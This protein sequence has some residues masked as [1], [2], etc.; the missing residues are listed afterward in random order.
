MQNNAENPAIYLVAVNSLPFYTNPVPTMENLVGYLTRGTR[1]TQIGPGSDG[2][3]RIRTAGNRI[4]YVQQALLRQISGP[5]DIL[6]SPQEII[7]YPPILEETEAE[8]SG[9]DGTAVTAAEIEAFAPAPDPQAEGE[10]E[11]SPMDPPQEQIEA[12]VAQASPQNI[13]PEGNLQAKN[14]EPGESISENKDDLAEQAEDQALQLP[15]EEEGD[16]SSSGDITFDPGEDPAEKAEDEARPS[17]PAEAT[18]AL[19]AHQEEGILEADVNA[20]LPEEGTASPEIAVQDSAGEA[21]E[22]TA[23]KEDETASLEDQS[24]PVYQNILPTNQYKVVVRKL[25]LRSS[26]EIRE[27]NIIGTLYQGDIVTKLSDGE[28]GFAFVR[29]R[30]GIQGYA[31]ERYLVPYIPNSNPEPIPEH[32]VSTNHANYSYDQML[33]DIQS[34]IHYFP[35]KASSTAIGTSVLGRKIPALVVGNPN[36]PQS[37]LFQSAIHG[38]EHMTTP[39]VMVQAERLLKDW[40]ADMEYWGIPLNELLNE[41]KFVVVPMANP[42]GVM[43]SQQGLDSVADPKRQEYLLSINDNSSD[44]TQWKANANGVDL[45]RNFG[46]DWRPQ[47]EGPGPSGY[48]G[49]EVWSEPETR[50]LRNLTQSLRPLVTNSYHARGEVIFWYFMQTGMQYIRD[51]ELAYQLGNLTGYAVVPPNE[52]G[53]SYGGYKD[54]FIEDYELPG[55]TIEIGDSLA[56]VPLPESQWEKIYEDNKDVALFLLKTAYAK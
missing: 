19:A 8:A 15:N 18:A 1:I 31:S 24:A 35:A 25:N 37:V 39:L 34:L 40:E 2:Y 7:P 55:F 28:N 16:S 49:P 22:A 29:A 27:N 51:E 17:S 20:A 41:V 6:P 42:D 10:P 23:A 46:G 5:V 9:T 54:W 52:S 26:P 11:L 43:L 32:I 38:R 44:F 48:S 53:G 3:I 21:G 56:P 50:A 12:A 33:R 13:G 4:G 30:Y 36:A 47:G 14:P 45:N